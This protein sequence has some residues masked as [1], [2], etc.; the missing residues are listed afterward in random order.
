MFLLKLFHPGSDIKGSNGGERQ[1][2]LFAPGKK[3]AA[4]A[5]IG[6]PG[7]IVVD[8]GGEEFD[9]APIGSI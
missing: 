4:G 1:P 3:P 5:R 6:P 2:A 9:V 8:I 7:V